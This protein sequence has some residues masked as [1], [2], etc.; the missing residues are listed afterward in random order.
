MDALGR[1]IDVGVAW[2]PVDA[3]SAQT[4][5]RCYV[6]D[7]GGVTVVVVKA[8]G[9]AGDD[10]SYTLK[11]YTAAS[12]GTTADLDA[13]SYYYI[14]QETALD[15]DEAWE[16]FTQTADAAI[17]EA[18]AA[19]TSAEQQQIIVVEVDSAQLSDGYAW[20]GFDSGGEGSNAQLATAIYIKHD[21][22]VQRKPANLPNLLNPGAADA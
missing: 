4:G 12:S 19:G 8:A 21:L 14:K 20:I 10:F 7:C 13:I 11:Q 2:V 22:K 18:G 6:G 5:K 17:T 3:Q 15:N 9:T 1:L 16:K